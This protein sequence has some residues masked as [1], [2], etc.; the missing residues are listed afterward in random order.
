MKKNFWDYYLVRKCIACKKELNPIGESWICVNS[1][2][3]RFGLWTAA[4]KEV[5]KR[6]VK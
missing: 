5:Y 4:W 6:W 3:K 1:K 2:C